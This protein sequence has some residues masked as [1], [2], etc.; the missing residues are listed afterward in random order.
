MISLHRSVLILGVLSLACLGVR[1]SQTAG[2][3]GRANGFV[4]EPDSQISRFLSIAIASRGKKSGMYDSVLACRED[5]NYMEFRWIAD[6][7]V[8]GT[9]KYADS[10]VASVVVTRVAMVVDSGDT[11]GWVGILG[12][13]EDTTTFRLVRD[14]STARTWKVCGDAWGGWSVMAVEPRNTRWMPRG[15]SPAV[16]LAMVDSIRKA[17]NLPLV[18]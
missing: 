14:S 15:S 12:V 13:H 16:A 3:S 4:Q 9:R 7:S 10:A 5:A 2:P 18:R 8:L 6:Y 11:G 17:R 1:N